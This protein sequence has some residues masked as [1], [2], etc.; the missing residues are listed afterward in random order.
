[1]TVSFKLSPFLNAL[2]SLFIDKVSALNL[3]AA[4]SNE[5]LVLVLGS[6]NRVTIVLPLRVGTFLMSRFDISSSDSAVSR[7]F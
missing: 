6:K 7:I 4:S 1:M 3:F 2:A 5:V